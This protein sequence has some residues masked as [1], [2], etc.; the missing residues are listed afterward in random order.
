MF[1]RGFVM[2][3]LL[4]AGST[5]L[6]DEAAAPAGQVKQ[7]KV[8][9]DLAP[10]CSTLK[11]IAESVTRGTKNNDE[12]AVAVYN[13]MN[14]THYHRNYP[15]EP[16][17]VPA[18]KE[19]NCY[20]WSLCGGL[21][22]EQSS[23]WRELGW[24]W[25]FTGWANPGHTTVEAQY[26]GRW[27]YVDIFLKF[28]AWMPDGNGGRTIAGED[29]L[30]ARSQELVTDAFV[31]DKG[32]N[33]VYAK[34][35][36]FVMSGEKANWRAPAFLSCGDG[37]DGVVSGLHSKNIAG[38]PE[39]WAGINHATG[40]YSMDVNLAPGFSLENTW[41]PMPDAWYWAGNKDAPR[42]TCGGHKDTRNDPGYGLILEPYINSK[43]GR[44]Y[45][46]GIL[47]FAPDFSSDIFLKSFASVENVK[48]ADKSL[49]PVEA[50]KPATVVVQLMS[51]YILTKA[52]GEA[53]GAGKVE[54]SVDGGKTFKA[55]ELKD[56]DAAV[57]GSVAALVKIT[58]KDALKTLKIQAIVQ[59]NPG[60]LP[61]LSPG[62]NKVT[63]SVA[64]PKALG[65]NKLIVTYA[66]RLGSRTKTFEQLCDQGKEVAKQH[67]AKWSDTITYAQKIFMAKDLPATFDIDCPT[68]KG[69]YPV[70]PRMM[71]MR[72]EVLAPSSEPMALPAD[73]VPAKAASE[74]ELQSLPNPFLVGTE[75]PPVAKPRTV[76]T[77]QIPLTY[78]EFVNDKGEVTNS[79]TLKWPK[80]DADF[81]KTLSSAVMVSGEVTGLPTKGL[82]AARLMVPVVK[83][84]ASSPCKLGVVF[85]KTPIEPS[86]PLDVRTLTDV[87]GTTILPKQ[88]EETPEYTPAKLFPIDITRTIRAIAGGEKTF[89]GLAL[90]VVPDRGVD[91]GYTVRAV[92]SPTEK[93][94]IEL[95]VY[96]D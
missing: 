87:N 64:D 10:D 58:I 16:G 17:G 81:G 71:F 23:I 36:Q 3:S 27:H 30:K 50:G 74:A 55:A 18:L 69:E 42:H 66:Y 79:G 38:S 32:H 35:N 31:L 78:L 28:Y 95:D 43:P 61:F 60:A 68:P 92:I 19:I 41:D 80:T 6:A 29:D 37:L 46:N 65:E 5:A 83:A 22:S 1:L 34:D 94:V 82:A 63:V 88:P 47:T 14:L 8:Q 56:F 2:A 44:S 57:K 33:C 40:N 75:T 67:N 53:D 26:D 96:A 13:F 73:A 39:G 24:G 4:M 91:E 59:N 25:R 89:N 70:Y 62:K 21:H 48:Y 93:I 49:V 90:R 20:G 51:P 54:V 15:S 77:T 7:I 52:S 76:K 85:L 11:T 84:F 12:K 72:R 9:P 86:K 45:G